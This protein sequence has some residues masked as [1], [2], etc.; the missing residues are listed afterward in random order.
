M[1]T[2]RTQ[3][4]HFQDASGIE[5]L[6]QILH[7]LD[8]IAEAL[9][10]RARSPLSRA[11][12]ATLRTLLPAIASS[13]QDANFLVHEL[14]AHSSNDAQLKSAIDAALGAGGKS[15]TR[16]LGRLLAR[17]ENVAIEGHIVERLGPTR[18]GVLWE[19]RRV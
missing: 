1:S 5:L 12:K 13:V 9:R 6:G 16:S 7:R 8:E 18:D 10:P 4:H 15:R 11:D 14:M 19:V 17:A 2:D 3:V